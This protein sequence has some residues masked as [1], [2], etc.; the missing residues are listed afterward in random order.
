MTG[1]SNDE[2]RRK[3]RFLYLISGKYTQKTIKLNSPEIKSHHLP[4]QC[5][6]TAQL[7]P[8]SRSPPSTRIPAAS[9]FGSSVAC[10]GREKIDPPPRQGRTAGKT[11]WRR[12]RDVIYKSPESQSHNTRLER[13]AKE[14]WKNSTDVGGITLIDSSV[15]TQS[16]L[17][18]TL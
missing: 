3:T 13:S 10:K 9:P 11:K 16:G 1:S 18:S 2:S 4:G 7:S 15:C 14:G 8:D 17:S 5:S 6:K 12:N